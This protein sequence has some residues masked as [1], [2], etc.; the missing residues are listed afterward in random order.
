MIARQFNAAGIAAFR[1]FLAE[2]RT[3]PTR[4]VPQTLLVDPAF[5]DPTA[6]P[7]EVNPQEFK[8]RQAAAD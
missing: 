5:S 3:D 6:T 4:T 7:V 8:A 2:C 1:A